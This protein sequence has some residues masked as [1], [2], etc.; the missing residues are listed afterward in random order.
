MRQTAKRSSTRYAKRC[1]SVATLAVMTS[2]LVLSG[3]SE[4]ATGDA[5]AGGMLPVAGTAGDT[6]SAGTGG[7]AGSAGAELGGS[8]G[9]HSAGTAGGGESAAGTASGAGAPPAAGDGGAAGGDVSSGGSPG[10][11]GTSHVSGLDCAPTGA[12]SY[13]LVR[14]SEPISA[15]AAAYVLITAAMDLAVGYYNCYTDLSLDLEVRFDA[16]FAI[17]ETEGSII[18]FGAM[19]AMNPVTAMHEIAR[20]AGIGSPEFA[21]LVED[22]VFMGE[23]ATAE[24]RAITG[25][26]TATLYADSQQFWPYGLN[27]PN[28]VRD[29]SDLVNHCKLVVAI[30]ED[31]GL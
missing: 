17:V 16:T 25:D 23:S 19:D 12:V 30:R 28:E 4:A 24:L 18:R 11:A 22:G 10:S 21:A 14:A 26:E 20:I 6:T 31:L 5:G 13:T 2:L 29:L 15:E 7:V 9:V 8:A 1:V 27:Y 3:C